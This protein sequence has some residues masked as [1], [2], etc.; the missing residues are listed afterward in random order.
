MEN[1]G[2]GEEVSKSA[3]TRNQSQL[4]YGYLMRNVCELTHVPSTD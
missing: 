1:N 3:N 2:I 4:N